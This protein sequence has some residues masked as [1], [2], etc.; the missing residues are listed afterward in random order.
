M[1]RLAMAGRVVEVRGPETGLGRSGGEAEHD[2]VQD[3]ELAERALGTAVHVGRAAP[4]A[5]ADEASSAAL[6]AWSI[7]VKRGRLA[8]ISRVFSAASRR[9]QAGLGPGLGGSGVGAGVLAVV[10]VLRLLQLSRGRGAAAAAAADAEAAP[11]CGAGR[12]AAGAAAAAAEASP[13]ALRDGMKWLQRQSHPPG[14]QAPR[15]P[16]PPHTLRPTLGRLARDNGVRCRAKPL[17]QRRS[18]PAAAASSR[19]TPRRAGIHAREHRQ[20]T[21]RGGLQQPRHRPAPRRL[22]HQ[23]T[24]HHERGGKMSFPLRLWSGPGPRASSPDC[25]PTSSSSCADLSGDRSGGF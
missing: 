20:R 23:L 12:G 1:A 25:N 5:A 16:P 19:G 11:R 15:T 4:A 3:A 24:S 2:R 14:S 9:R 8:R 13:A 22:A 21:Q 7:S 6:M 18:S 10:L 17:P